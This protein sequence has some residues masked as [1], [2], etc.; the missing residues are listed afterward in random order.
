MSTQR[1]VNSSMWV[2]ACTRA[3]VYFFAS[4]TPKYR[5]QIVVRGKEKRNLTK[6]DEF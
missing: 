6:T 5:D 2:A 3:L 4:N 1:A